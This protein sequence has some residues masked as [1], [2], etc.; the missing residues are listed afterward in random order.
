VSHV[1]YR[2]RPQLTSPILICAF[3]GWNDG[4]EAATTAVRALRSQWGA[5]RFAEIDPEEFYDFQVHRPT[6]RLIDGATRRIDWPTNRFYSARVNDRDAV[7]FMG[8]EPNVRWRTFGATILQVCADLGVE[9]L[10][11]L[12]AFLADVPHTRPAPVNAASEDPDW[13]ERVGVF[14]ARYEGPTGIV[15]VVSAA[16]ARAGIPTL[17]LWAAAPHYLPQSR[18]P[19]VALALLEALRDL[20]GLEVDTGEIELAARMFERE[21]SEAIE[22]D[23]N[24]A[25]YVRRLEEAAEETDAEEASIE[26][27]NGDDLAAELEKYLREHDGSSED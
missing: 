2:A 15:G 10:V 22:E 23:G 8:V 14:P 6:V 5:R 17:S 21:V 26:V 18:N 12:G 1:D 3:D 24:L 4:G 7:V 25:D 27:P 9:L 20:T 11:T 19:K 13:L 16:A